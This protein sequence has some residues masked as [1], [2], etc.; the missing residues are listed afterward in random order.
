MKNN[1]FILEIRYWVT[2]L[3]YK[4]GLVNSCYLLRPYDV[5]KSFSYDIKPLF[6]N[7]ASDIRITNQEM[8]NDYFNCS[9]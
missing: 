9:N 8:K 6:D 7:S 2:L 4:L 5:K 1:W 3:A